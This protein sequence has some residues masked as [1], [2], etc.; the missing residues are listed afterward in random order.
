VSIVRAG[1]VGFGRAR[2]RQDGLV[3]MVGLSS[4]SWGARCQR[5]AGASIA[6]ARVIEGWGRAAECALRD[7]S[8]ERSVRTATLLSLNVQPGAIASR[9]VPVSWCSFVR[10]KV[11][12]SMSAQPGATANRS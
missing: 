11:H 1:Q 4:S 5:S 6:R 10:R 2:R 9:S 12:E 3:E 8:V 7:T